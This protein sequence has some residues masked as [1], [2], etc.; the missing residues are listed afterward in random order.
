MSNFREERLSEAAVQQIGTSPVPA[1]IPR[2]PSSCG[3]NLFAHQPVAF[4][5]PVTC[6]DPT[7]ERLEKFY[8]FDKLVIGSF[9]V[10]VG[11]WIFA[12]LSTGKISNGTLNSISADVGRNETR[13][14]T[15]WLLENSNAL[16]GN[17][18]KEPS[19]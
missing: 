12:V 2:L 6:P 19:R 5:A 17:D 18:R 14:C 9:D 7:I 8:P 3:F 10:F 1:R 16:A 13:D 11:P 4:L 15:T